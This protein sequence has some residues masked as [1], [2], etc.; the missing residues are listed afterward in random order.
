MLKEL[1]EANASISEVEIIKNDEL[2]GDKPSSKVVGKF[3]KDNLIYSFM[4][5]TSELISYLSIRF[6]FIYAS[7]DKK[8]NRLGVLEAV[9]AMN[10][11]FPAVKV[12]LNDIDG[13]SIK[14]NFNVEIPYSGID[15]LGV[16]LY[17]AIEVVSVAPPF[18]SKRFSDKNIAH[19]TI[20]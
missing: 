8:I 17:P 5:V 15:S 19:K 12:F 4:N 3:K 2:K 7:T 14:I 20:Y 6:Q 18:L 9:N 11:S 10:K 13:K 16:I 1:L